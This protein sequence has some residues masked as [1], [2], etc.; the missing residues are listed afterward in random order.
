MVWSSKEV[1]KSGQIQKDNEDK[2]I[3]MKYWLM[4]SEPESFSIDT[5]KSLRAQT[6]SW[7]GVRNYQARNFMRDEMQIGDKAF[8]YHS[9][10]EVPAIV[11][12]MEVVRES[13]PDFTAFDPESP[14]YDPKSSPKTPRWFMVDV[15]LIKKFKTI[16]PLSTLKNQLPLKNMQLLK[17]GNRLS[18]LPIAKSEWEYI[19]HLSE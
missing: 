16:I 15:K 18:I 13:Y 14:Y 12:I 11:G 4:K 19:L 17:Q 2:Q 10:C 1:Q 7:E 6:S 9:S 5:L 3:Q 8:F